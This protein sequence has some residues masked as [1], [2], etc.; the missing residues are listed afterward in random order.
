MN[1]NSKINNYAFDHIITCS[2]SN[3]NLKRFSDV[4]TFQGTLEVINGIG[5]G[6]NSFYSIYTKDIVS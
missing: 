6:I 3:G 2:P 5:Q 1:L 4:N